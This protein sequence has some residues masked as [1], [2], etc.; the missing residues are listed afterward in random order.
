MS[1]VSRATA[2]SP[3]SHLRAVSRPPSMFSAVSRSYSHPNYPAAPSVPRTYPVPALPTMSRPSCMSPAPSH[4]WV[5]C[6]MLPL[7]QYLPELYSHKYQCVHP[8]LLDQFW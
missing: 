8:E 1:A 3:M 4:W 5:W 7:S 6:R 2:V